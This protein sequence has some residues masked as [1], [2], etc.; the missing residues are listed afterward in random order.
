MPSPLATIS[1]LFC[2]IMMIIL[3]CTGTAMSVMPLLG[4]AVMYEV[5]R[6]VSHK[7]ISHFVDQCSFSRYRNCHTDFDLLR[8]RAVDT[9]LNPP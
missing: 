4:I 6:S 5:F 2:A 9:D 7:L 3:T 1:D 8:T